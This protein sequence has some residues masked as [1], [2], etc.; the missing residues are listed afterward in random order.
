MTPSAVGSHSRARRGRG[1]GLLRVDPPGVLLQPGPALGE[2]R[3]EQRLVAPASRSKAAK[4]AGI[5]RAGVDARGG[6]V[7]ALLEGPNSSP[8][9]AGI[10]ISPSS[11]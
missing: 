4:P 3:L 8:V 6:R 9:G 5:S 10:T 2:R 7:D 1:L 11:T